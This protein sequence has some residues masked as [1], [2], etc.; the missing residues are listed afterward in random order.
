MVYFYKSKPHVMKKIFRITLV[1]L[2]F[3]SCTKTSEIAIKSTNNPQNQISVTDKKNNF[4]YITLT[5][6]HY[7]KYYLNYIDSAHPGHLVY[8]RSTGINTAKLSSDTIK[9]LSNGAFFHGNKHKEEQGQWT[10]ADSAQSI[11]KITKN[12]TSVLFNIQALDKNHYN[13]TA[14]ANGGYAYAEMIPK[15]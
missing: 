8:D 2:L 15:H 12:G 7:N 5:T 1:V 6:W 13:W 9:F 10:F 3:V 11:I 4:Y 14:P